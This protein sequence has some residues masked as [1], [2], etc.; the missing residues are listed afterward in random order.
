MLTKRFTFIRSLAVLAVLMISATLAWA[1]VGSGTISG[2]VTDPSGAVIPNAAV[3]IRNTQTGVVRQAAT[4]TE[5]LYVAPGLA[6]GNYEVEVRVQG[7]KTQVQIVVLTVGSQ[8]VVDVSLTTGAVSETVNV[9][10]DAA[11]LQTASSEISALIGQRQL[12]ELPL[13]GRNYEQ[14]ILLAPGVQRSTTSVQSSFYGRAPSY[15]VA[16]SRPV[17]QA[18]WLDGA[19]I[20]GFWEHASGNAVVGTSL[21]VEAIGEFQVMTNTYTARFSGSGSVVNAATRS[22]TNDWHGSA[23]E[24]LRNSATDALNFFDNP[25]TPPSLRRN[26]YGGTIGGP[27]KQNKSFFFVNYEGLRQGRGLTAL[28]TVPD[29]N[30][31]NGLVPC[32]SAPALPCSNGLA[33]V[34]VNAKT[35]PILDLFPQANSVNLGGG[36]ARFISV[37]NQIAKEDFVTTRVDHTF[38]NSHSA[39]ARYVFDHGT[40][41]DPATAY[42]GQ[43]PGL[44]PELS[45]GRNQYF[46]VEDKKII[47]ST[48]VNLARFSFVRTYTGAHTDANYPALDFYPGENRQN[49]RVG[50]GPLGVFGPSQF[51]PFFSVQNGYSIADDVALVKGKHSLEFGVEFRRLQSNVVNNF[52]TS[53]TYTFTTLVS[54]LQAAPTSFLGAL[55]RRAN[56]YRGFRENRIYPYVQDTWKAS[57]NLTLNLGLRW[58]FQSNPREVNGLLFAFVDP[59]KDAGYTQVPQVFKTNPT[60]K[61]FGPRLG[62]AWDPFQ[63]HK[64]VI[65]AGGGLFY[66]LFGARNYQPAYL[67]AG[68][69]QTALQVSPS[70]PVPFQGSSIPLIT[71]SNAMTY[72]PGSTPYVAQYNLNIQRQLPGNFILTTSYVGSRG[73]NMLVPVDNNPVVPRN[74]NGVQVYQSATNPAIGQSA[75]R[76]NPNTSIGALLFSRPNGP[77]WYNSLQLYL[78]RN[79]A[80]GLQMQASFTYS[81]CLDQGSVSYGLEGNAAGAQQLNPYDQ[82]T[83]RALCGFDVRRNFTGNVIYLL[84]F[85][86]NP[87]ISG[88]QASLIASARTGQPF[89]LN[90]GFDRTSIGGAARPDLVPGRSANPILGRVEQWYD[91]TAFALQA[92]GTFGTLGRDTLTGPG[93]VNFDVAL[94]KTFKIKDKLNAQFRAEGFNIFNH[95]NFGMPNLNLYTGPACSA[96]QTGNCVG[97]GIPNPNAGRITST[98]TTSRQLQFALKLIF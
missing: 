40:L 2:A 60:W 58:D 92:P 44:F 38:S 1:Q 81:K 14:L 96:G 3:S 93:L 27:I 95:P 11:Q 66:S 34:G 61:N 82:T 35:K 12:R 62:F 20:Q 89:T 75:P 21:G 49:G 7:F 85:K 18:V 42:T 29:A 57:R 43:F 19:D 53:G 28:A 17:G 59:A 15:S 50:I 45:R 48:L 31:R 73:V 64:T 5:G 23:Y 88:W 71:I 90:D 78:T 36:V 79:L 16:G 63:D 67:F 55:P 6:V 8:L 77:S 83:E 9:T 56:A 13:N 51:S 65:R 26:Q 70:F 80:Q 4:N 87:L 10:A 46:T 76:L 97:P 22:G 24:F 74:V 54:F 98:V 39:F 86:G 32:A 52:F 84:P 33:N 41:L 72:D 94:A 69:Y 25:A 68:P 37:Q 91:P 30:A 47:S